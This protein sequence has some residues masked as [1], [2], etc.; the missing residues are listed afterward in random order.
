MVEL[1]ISGGT[2]VI[3][4]FLENARA[5]PNGGFQP[6]M[7]LTPDANA[8]VTMLAAMNGTFQYLTNAAA[9]FILPTG[10]AAGVSV[11]VAGVNAVTLDAAVGVVLNGGASGANLALTA[12]PGAATVVSLGGDAYAVIGDVS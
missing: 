9:T 3:D 4:G 2:S 6:P 5:N 1:N 8:S 7:V 10:M 11:L 12:L